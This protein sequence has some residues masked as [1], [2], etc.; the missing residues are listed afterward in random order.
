MKAR[1]DGRCSRGVPSGKEPRVATVY[2]WW[3][4]RWGAPVWPRHGAWGFEDK[5]S[6]QAF[7][8]KTSEIRIRS[9]NLQPLLCFSTCSILPDRSFPAHLHLSI[10]QQETSNSAPPWH[11]GLGQTTLIISRQI[12]PETYV[13]LTFLPASKWSSLGVSIKVS[14]HMEPGEEATYSHTMFCSI[15]HGPKGEFL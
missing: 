2:A 8:N 4:A 5:G 10:Y 1:V 9:Q 15:S 12:F 13:L 6:C 3:E 14:R 11:V 7:L